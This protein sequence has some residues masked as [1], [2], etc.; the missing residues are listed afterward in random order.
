MNAQINQLVR[1]LLQKDS[2]DQCSLQELEQFADRHPYFG[3]AQLLLTKKMQTESP[4]RYDEQL[5]KT[6]LFFHNPLW[7]QHLLSDNGKATIKAAEKKEETLQPTPPET[8]GTTQEEF[9]SV[10]PEEPVAPALVTIEE[11]AQSTAPGIVPVVTE[12]SQPGAVITETVEEETINPAPGEPLAPAPVINEEPVMKIPALKFEP[13][14]TKKTDLLF[15][16]YHTVDYFASQG[17]KFREEEKPADKLGQQLKSFTD[18]LKVMKR[19]PVSE[20]V[21]NVEAKSEEKVEQLAEHSLEDREVVTETMA[22]VWEKQGNNAKAIEIYDK[23]SLLYPSKSTYFAAK[24]E[25]LKK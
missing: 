11:P 1:S 19:L 22:E 5:Q 3:A 17:I 21:K 20:I 7:V 24:I 4:E 12:E 25:A 10:A 23:L 15:E 13:V 14:D 18:W 2:I 8:T 6:F 9:I 16:P